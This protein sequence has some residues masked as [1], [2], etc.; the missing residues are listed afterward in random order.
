[1]RINWLSV[2][3][4]VAALFATGL[5]A[6]KNVDGYA[7]HHILNVSYDPTRELYQKINPAF[8]ALYE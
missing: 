2:G 3:G 4:I 8:A 1:M 7:P 6:A 5:I